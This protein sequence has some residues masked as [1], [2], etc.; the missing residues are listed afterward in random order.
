MPRLARLRLISIGNVEA[1][2]EDLTLNFCDGAGTPDDA[3]VWLRN[4]GGKST[5]LRLFFSMILPERRHFIGELGQKQPRI[6]DYLA[7][8]DCAVVVA[9]WEKEG[10]ALLLGGVAVPGRYL[11]GV[12]REQPRAG[13]VNV[14]P[15][16]YFF[17]T[18]V[19][20]EEP[21]LTLDG[22]PLIVERNGQRTRR[23]LLGFKQEWQ[24]LG[25]RYGATEVKEAST[26]HAWARILD[27]ADIDPG[28]FRYQIE[29]NRQEGGAH[30][31]FKFS[32]VDDFVD[33][34]L[35]LVLEPDVGDRVGVTIDKY[36]NSLKEREAL[37]SE[38]DL[39]ASLLELAPQL[40]SLGRGRSALH[41]RG[42]DL[43][44]DLSRLEPHIEDRVAQESAR[45][46]EASA[47]QIAA[48]ERAASA[49]AEA[50]TLRQRANSLRYHAAGKRARALGILEAQAE[51]ELAS[52]NRDVGI[53]T[54]AIPLRE[55]VYHEKRAED[56]RQRLEQTSAEHP[57]EF[58]ALITAAEHYAA[59]LGAAAAEL[60]AQE[61][62][63]T[64]REESARASAADALK[65]ATDDEHTAASFR[66]QEQELVTRLD[67][68][69]GTRSAL[70]TLG[71]ISPDEPISDA[72]VRWGD[73][74]TEGKGRLTNAVDKVRA[75]SEGVEANRASGQ[76]VQASLVSS[77]NRHATLL[78]DFNHATE[79]KSTIESNPLLVRCLDR[80]SINLEQLDT[81]EVLTRLRQVERATAEKV[82]DLRAQR[83]ENERA[84]SSLLDT[85]LLP[86]ERDVQHLCSLL[87][88]QEIRAWS[89]WYYF[90]HNVPQEQLRSA[91]IRSPAVARGVV[92]PDDQFDEARDYLKG[93][94]LR[95]EQP[96]VVARQSYNPGQIENDRVVV[97]PSSDAQFDRRVARAEL[98]ERERR[99]KHQ[100]GLLASA[101]KELTNIGNLIA[102][103]SHFRRQYPVGWFQTQRAA[104]QHEVDVA[105]E[106]ADEG[107]KLA[108][109]ADALAIETSEAERHVQQIQEE[110]GT[111]REHLARLTAFADTQPD[112]P[113][114][115]E[116]LRQKVRSEAEERANAALR[117]RMRIP[118]EEASVRT[119]AAAAKHAG[120]AA[121]VHE[122]NL[123]A[124]NYLEGRQVEPRAGDT[125]LLLMRYRDLESEFHARADTKTLRALYETEKASEQD[126]RK[127]FLREL[128][129]VDVSE[130]EVLIALHSLADPGAVTERARAAREAAVALSNSKGLLT[131]KITT[132]QEEAKRLAEDAAKLGGVISALQEEGEAENALQIA[133]AADG[134][135]HELEEL[136]RTK[137]DEAREAQERAGDADRRYERFTAYQKEIANLRE[138]Y[139]RVLSP[140]PPLA[141]TSNSWSVPEDGEVEA[142]IA[143]I[144]GSLGS[145]LSQLES[146][147]RQAGAVA[148]AMR[149]CIDDS[150]FDKL[151]LESMR[152]LKGYSP[153]V[154]EA[155]GETIC[156]DLTTRVAIINSELKELDTHR[157]V[158]IASLS[159]AADTGIQMLKAAARVKLP[160][161][162]ENL[163]HRNALEIKVTEPA[164]PAEA[165]ERIGRLIDGWISSGKIPQGRKIIHQVVKCLAKPIHVRVLFPDPE[166]RRGY[167]PVDEF[168]RLSGGERITCAVMLFAILAKHR[169]WR[170]GISANPAA[171]L[172]LDNP[173]GGSSRPKFLN[174]Q[175][176][177]AR[178]M[179][180]QLIYAT[181][182]ND[183]EA[184][185]VF[186]L[187]VRL[188]NDRYDR[189]TGRRWV[190]L[191]G[192]KPPIDGARLVFPD[193]TEHSP[194]GQEGAVPDATRITL[195]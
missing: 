62:D 10:D 81:E 32:E 154:L 195:P 134:D 160:E 80:E 31:L 20:P 43:N 30:E 7:P 164:H 12:F 46:A 45:R 2:F 14:S 107:A 51:T 26:H 93:A 85:E 109:E 143:S 135:A 96:V 110:L 166:G 179:G 132:A 106:L 18:K 181:G 83:A 49:G 59:A 133:D 58:T 104:M 175:R 65:N 89:G 191:A 22:L 54:A 119:N 13:A 15:E 157:A 52:A 3:V 5:L 56:H 17:A 158:I 136:S 41:V 75:T 91:I 183:P 57:V 169:A 128:E 11:T 6:E 94:D 23:P 36:R 173:I 76:Q 102:E 39:V 113:V 185:R 37:M 149:K 188:R 4:A 121:R 19:R 114:V 139:S 144:S 168:Y 68:V 146:C 97:G 79:E 156:E 153:E 24:D 112:E 137:T 192:S 74:L 42:A 122:A 172:I 28:L 90:S 77:Q 127:R 69:V 40:Q 151:Q 120:E 92:V 118:L 8:G 38:R 182:V 116:R 99:L 72:S 73:F 184:L 105:A 53:W 155:E 141:P 165:Q 34:F 115:I 150:R 108:A 9:E 145:E 16:T 126:A 21:H 64:R 130:E 61:K 194:T 131:G 33:F 187:I 35:D 174:L 48:S 100:Q 55:A 161:S 178:A 44:L 29:M 125:T 140:A 95:L 47:K 103:L 176:E 63:A 117:E 87:E 50:R 88:A 180:V 171:V 67:Q 82:L 170:R 66:I 78:R 186:P 148:E 159:S 163:A 25:K 147:D 138:R 193:H 177:V 124:V 98:A 123:A 189:R 190:E 1:R 70:A 84:I 71:V 152:R 27:S 129:G 86:P 167:I 162:L 111:A 60:R 101:E 142:R